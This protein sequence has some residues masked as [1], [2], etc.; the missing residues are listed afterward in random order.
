MSVFITPTNPKPMALMMITT[1]STGMTVIPSS[2]RTRRLSM[3]G[4]PNP[5]VGRTQSG[6]T[7]AHLPAGGVEDDV[8]HA[9]PVRPP[10]GL[11]DSKRPGTVG[12]RR[13]QADGCPPGVHLDPA[14]HAGLPHVSGHP[15]HG[16]PHVLLHGQTLVRGAG[17][18][19]DRDEDL[20]DP[21]HDEG[22]DGHADH[23]VDEQETP[24]G[25]VTSPHGSGACACRSGR[26]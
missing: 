15:L 6:Y 5:P 20:V 9:L 18:I 10:A 17:E 2:R 21:L 13:G 14:G 3:S 11:I 7:A 22:K 19:E 24:A 8:D 23:Q 25:A 26:R 12:A 1:T 4:P 16:Q